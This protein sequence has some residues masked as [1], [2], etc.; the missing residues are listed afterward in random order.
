MIQLQTPRC[1]L[2]NL[3]KLIPVY[4]DITN[5]KLQK[6]TRKDIRYNDTC[7]LYQIL[8][9]MRHLPGH[10]E[11]NDELFPEP[12]ITTSTEIDNL[13]TIGDD[14]SHENSDE[15]LHLSCLPSPEE[16]IQMDDHTEE[17][18]QVKEME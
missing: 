10:T 11:V 1:C 6:N 13:D 2:E 16:A 8:G 15:L 3:R 4:L 12:L 14:S 7:P 18:I 5:D 9:E 17:I